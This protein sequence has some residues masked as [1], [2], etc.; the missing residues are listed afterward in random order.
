MT[1]ECIRPE[2]IARGY[3][4]RTQKARKTQRQVLR[5]CWA[6]DAECFP[7]RTQRRRGRRRQIAALLR[8]PDEE[9]LNMKRSSPPEGAKGND[10]KW[11]VNFREY[12]YYLTQR[13]R[14]TQK[15]A[16]SLALPLGC[17]EL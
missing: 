9:L 8:P 12:F 3:L 5:S 2:G 1:C 7:F 11:P 15:N 6:A 4:Y 10:H 14:K 17:G 16:C 13:R